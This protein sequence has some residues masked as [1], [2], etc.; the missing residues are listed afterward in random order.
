MLS[1]GEKKGLG[2][3]AWASLMAASFGCGFLALALILL[4]FRL[5]GLETG[6]RY[7]ERYVG[8]MESV[9]PSEVAEVLSEAPVA[10]QRTGED[11]TE[12]EAEAEG[13]EEADTKPEG[14]REAGME[15]EGPGEV[16]YSEQSYMELAPSFS[17]QRDVIF[18]IS[19]PDNSVIAGAFLQSSAGDRFDK[20]FLYDNG[21]K[22]YLCFSIDKPPAGLWS[23][24]ISG[25]GLYEN[26]EFLSYQYK[27]F[28]K[29]YSRPYSEVNNGERTG[30]LEEDEGDAEEVEE[31]SEMDSRT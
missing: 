1:D 17:G 11:E 2:G 20:Y 12:T 14:S 4:V 27:D 10:L 30:F 3:K 8:E 23:M 28:M 15:A 13:Y 6:E 29:L 26:P 18:F 19:I 24:T 22:R 31:I 21:D 9:V 25:D 7:G 16:F 5:F